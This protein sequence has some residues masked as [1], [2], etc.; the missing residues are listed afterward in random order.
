MSAQQTQQTRQRQPNRHLRVV[1]AREHNLK[2]VTVDVPKGQLTV[3]YDVFGSGK[4]SLVFD[5]IAAESQRQLNETFTTFVRNRLPKYGQPDVDAIE[6]LSAAIVVGQ[7]RIGGNTRSTVGTVTDIYSLMRLLW[8]RAGQP[9]VGYSNVFS[10]N[11]P[12]GMCQECSGLGMVRTVTVDQLVDR[13]RSLDEGAIRFP[14]FKSGSWMWRTYGGSAMFDNDKPLDEYSEQEWQAFLYGAEGM[15]QRPD[16]PVPVPEKY[17][18]LLPRF[19]R[20]WLP[21]DVESL[22][23]NTREAFER[24]VVQD[25]C[26]ACAGARLSQESL[27]CKVDG[28]NIA[29]CAALEAVDLIEFV[30]E[31]DAPASAPIVA[32]LTA[33][34]QRLIAIGLGY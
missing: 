33:Q 12:Q 30:R 13:S 27:S 15:L 1:G 14:T 26:P 23:G 25:T 6:N 11:D 7:K 19:E 2:D 5:T 28:R 34:L 8:S 22:R 16:R 31:V 9:F 20:I 3:V 4:S 17:E 21:K 10:F 29:E 24:V 32:T 18:G